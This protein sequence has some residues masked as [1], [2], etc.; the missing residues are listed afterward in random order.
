M[1][2]QTTIFQ[3]FVASPSDVIE[4]RA[5]LEQ[6]ISELNQIWSRSLG[7][8]LELLRW[9]T[10]VRPAFSLD[11]Q[12]VINDQIG[13]DYDVF[14]GIFWGRFGAATSRAESGTLEEFERAYSRFTNSETVPE[15]MLYFKDAPI[16]PSKLDPA[17]L[18]GV[19]DF[20]RSL[21]ARGGLYYDFEDSSGFESSVRAHL[22]AVA[23]KLSQSRFS[24]ILAKE[25][26]AITVA[27]DE[28]ELGYFDH[29]EMYESKI[30]EM[31]IAIEI[32]NEA[33]IR[34]G[35]QVSQHAKEAEKGDP[36]N[37]KAARRF[38]TRAADDMDSYAT[39]MKA[40]VST[41]SSTRVVAFNSLSS[42]LSLRNDFSRNGDEDLRELRESLSSM[43]EGSLT[44]RN[45]M[46]GMRV[47]TD[48]LPRMSKE[49]NKAKRAVVSQIDGLLSELDSVHSTINNIVE[50]IDQMLGE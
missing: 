12:T 35:E 29:I 30:E 23:Q 31:T 41:L 15:I 28:D 7:L 2:R 40:Q 50:A 46:A 47:A 4:E 24:T 26:Q 34:V 44:A 6:V 38:V 39:I 1:A 42:A 10:N 5:I 36:Q 32:I 3:V 14:I 43:K 27:E 13:T 16:A 45:A 8:T 25:A 22:S 11:P 17:Q 18:K 49:L 21:S 33:T 9:E 19:Q 37:I 48:G 20:K